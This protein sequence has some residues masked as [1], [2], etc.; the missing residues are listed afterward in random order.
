MK[1]SNLK[2]VSILCQKSFT[3]FTP[4]IVLTLLRF[5]SHLPTGP[6]SYTRLGRLARD[7]QSSFLGPFASFKK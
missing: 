4:G 6:I 2:R 5:L 1:R 3:R 7:K